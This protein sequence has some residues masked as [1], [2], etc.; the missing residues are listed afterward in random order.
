[1]MTSGAVRSPG[2]PRLL[3]GPD[4]AA[5]WLP[6]GAFDRGP[7]GALGALRHANVGPVQPGVRG[8]VLGRRVGPG[9]ALWPRHQQGEG[10]PFPLELHHV[11]TLPVGPRLVGLLPQHTPRDIISIMTS[12]AS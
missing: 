1:M 5:S 12:S 6:D 4:A 3:G 8:V 2:R 11:Q 7:D 9:P 10:P